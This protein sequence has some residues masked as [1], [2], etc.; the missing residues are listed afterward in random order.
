MIDKFRG[1][2]VW[3]SNFH[4]SFVEVGPVT[5]GT[6]EAAYQA[7][8]AKTKNDFHKILNSSPNTAKVLGRKVDIVENWERIKVIVM[9]DLLRQKFKRHSM[10]SDML[11]DTDPQELL[12]GNT[13]H[14]NFWGDCY[15]GGCDNIYGQNML[16]KLLMQVRRELL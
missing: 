9:L 2:Y 1:D 13:W 11:V 16:G 6:V 3:L 10:L 4:P 15:C 8:K 7:L 5:A 14:D 12:E